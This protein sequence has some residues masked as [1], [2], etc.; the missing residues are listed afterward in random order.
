QDFSLE[1]LEYCEPEKLLIREKYYIDLGTEYNIVKDPT[2]NP[3][4]GRKHSDNTKTKISD[5]LKG[6]KHSE[7]T[8]TIMSEKKKGNTN[9]KNHPNSQVIEVL[10]KDNN[11]TTTYN[12]MGEAARALNLPSYKTIANYILHG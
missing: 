11:K 12:S 9:S 2:I 1:I 5:T 7:K 3:M 4:A 8:K 6:H 10:D